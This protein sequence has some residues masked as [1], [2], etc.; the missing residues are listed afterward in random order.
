MTAKNN[1][2]SEITDEAPQSATGG[3]TG[4]QQIAKLTEPGDVPGIEK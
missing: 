2:P 1:T 3:L 4:Y